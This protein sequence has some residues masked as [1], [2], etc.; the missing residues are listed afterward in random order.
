M[1]VPAH[2]NRDFDFASIH[3]INI[4]VVI[5]KEKHSKSIKPTKAYED[6]GYLINSNQYNGLKNTHAKDEIIKQGEEE[7]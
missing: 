3:N 6:I 2:D 4:N 7:G 5:E 1:G